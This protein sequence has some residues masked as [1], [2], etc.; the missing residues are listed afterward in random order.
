MKDIQDDIQQ[1]IHGQLQDEDRHRIAQLIE[2]DQDY[3]KEYSWQQEL[4]VANRNIEKIHFKKL[5]QKIEKQN[6]DSRANKWAKWIGIIIIIGLLALILNRHYSTA[7]ADNKDELYAYYYLPYPNKIAPAVRSV[8]L[9][10]LQSAFIA[11]DSG[12]HLKAL[13]LF[14][15]IEE[16]ISQLDFYKAICLMSLERYDEAIDYFE[17]SAYLPE[18]WKGEAL[19]YQTLCLLKTADYA[20]TDLLLD[21]IL[22]SSAAADLKSKAKRL[23]EEV[24]SLSIL[25]K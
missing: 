5:L 22:S 10:M 7:S 15:Q 19:W 1:Y 24:K 17:H 16:N 6:K 21:Q 2:L 18:P 9:S 8:E 4:M 13:Q 14:K 12:D 25:K 20:K 23:Q 3:Q 11:Y